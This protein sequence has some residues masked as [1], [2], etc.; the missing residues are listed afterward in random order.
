MNCTKVETSWRNDAG[1]LLTFDLLALK[2]T[3]PLIFVNSEA[4]KQTAQKYMAF[5]N[6]SYK[7]PT[8]LKRALELYEVRIEVPPFAVPIA[9]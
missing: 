6:H 1:R 9:M 2:Q 5:R 7:E 4:P 8:V 3:L